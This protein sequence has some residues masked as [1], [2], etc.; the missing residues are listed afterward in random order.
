MI[1]VTTGISQ[2]S[3]ATEKL[4]LDSDGLLHLLDRPLSS[5]IAEEAGSCHD[6]VDEDAEDSMPPSCYKDSETEDQCTAS[7]QSY[8]CTFY[9]QALYKASLLSSMAEK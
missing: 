4:P 1:A 7:K 3:V 2:V 8:A 5:A 6:K 9:I